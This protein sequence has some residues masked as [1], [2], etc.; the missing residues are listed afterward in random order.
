[1]PGDVEIPNAERVDCIARRDV[2]LPV[3]TD[4]CSN[5][6]IDISVVARDGYSLKYK[7]RVQ[8]QLSAYP[9]RLVFMRFVGI[10]RFFPLSARKRS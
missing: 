9:E 4:H 5:I 10:F 1:M 2:F 8:H 7:S 3:Q 6:K